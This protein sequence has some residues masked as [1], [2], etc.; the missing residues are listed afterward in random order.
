MLTEARIRKIIPK[1]KPY[2]IRD[3]DGLYLE[4]TPSGGK[5]WRLRYWVQG[6]RRRSPSACIP[7]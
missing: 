3:D 6:K 4:V 7:K 2:M 1:D 5:Y